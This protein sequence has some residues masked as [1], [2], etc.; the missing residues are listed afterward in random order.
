[1]KTNL[2]LMAFVLIAFTSKSNAQSWVTH[3]DNF[4]SYTVGTSVTTLGYTMWECGASIKADIVANSGLNYASMAGTAA[5]SNYMRKTLPVIAG[6]NYTFSVYTAAPVSHNHSLGYRTV[7]AQTASTALFTNTEWTKHDISFT[8]NLSENADFFIYSYGAFTIH[9]DDWEVI[10]NTAKII[11]GT[12]NT[13][14]PSIE[15]FKSGLNQLSINGCEVASCNVY[16]VQGKLVKRA[17]T[18]QFDL[19]NMEKGVYLIKVTDKAGN[20]FNQK[21][22]L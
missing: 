9:S 21:L 17:Y 5:K 4:D 22:L 19:N 3:T 8:A 2:L 20:S 14:S 10:D 15:I 16:N 1:M 6:H 13:F 11:A 12:K 7:S 18:N